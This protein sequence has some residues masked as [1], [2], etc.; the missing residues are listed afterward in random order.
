MAAPMLW[1]MAPGLSV[2]AQ[3]ARPLGQPASLISTFAL[4]GAGSLLLLSLD[5]KALPA[6]RPGGQ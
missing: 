1:Q 6:Q 4:L 5:Q 2:W 3:A